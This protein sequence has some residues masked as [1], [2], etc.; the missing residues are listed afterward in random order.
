MAE[1][2]IEKLPAEEQKV[3]K[4]M[5]SVL[6]Q[7]FW[8]LSGNFDSEAFRKYRNSDLIFSQFDMSMVHVAFFETVVMHPK[9]VNIKQKL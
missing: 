5:D 3:F 2:A 6:L 8:E 9:S 4:K 1:S 7:N